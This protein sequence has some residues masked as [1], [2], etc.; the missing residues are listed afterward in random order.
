MVHQEASI[1]GGATDD[2][3][4]W[5]RGRPREARSRGVATG[6]GR[7]LP[8]GVESVGRACR[9]LRRDEPGVWIS[10]DEYA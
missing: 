6:P 4:P 8:F 1:T 7:R 9:Y 5:M 3:I 10:A 2:I